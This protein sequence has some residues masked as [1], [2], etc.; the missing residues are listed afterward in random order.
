VIALVRSVMCDL[1]PRTSELP[2]IADTGVTEFLERLRREAHSG[3]WL[4]V[5]LGSVVYALTPL[6]TVF[7][8]LPSFLLPARL[9][10]L[11]ARRIVS[12]NLYLVRQA[13]FLVRLSA[14]M[15][16]G[17][18]PAVRARFAL[19]AYPLDPGTFRST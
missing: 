14:G 3:F 18:D 11:H 13:V 2:G 6:L 12:T 10:D 7:L 8:P 19:D 5:V 16:W 1:M 4:G 17:A 9:R 15:C